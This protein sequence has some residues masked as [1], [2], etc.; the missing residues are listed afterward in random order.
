MLNTHRLSKTAAAVS[1]VLASMSVCAAQALPEMGVDIRVDTDLT[2]L[3]L[4]QSA[5]AAKNI[6]GRPEP[7][8]RPQ[9][10]KPDV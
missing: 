7:H 8:T 5:Y 1:A 10:R 9:G 6:A 4:T 3:D 2:Q